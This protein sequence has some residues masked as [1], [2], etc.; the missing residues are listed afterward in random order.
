MFL[1]LLSQTVYAE[2]KRLFVRDDCRVRCLEWLK[3]IRFSV[4][5]RTLCIVVYQR[6]FSM[7]VRERCFLFSYSKRVNNVHGMVF[8]AWKNSWCS[9]KKK[10]PVVLPPATL[11]KSV[12]VAWRLR[13][14]SGRK[15]LPS[16]TWPSKALYSNRTGSYIM[17]TDFW[18]DPSP[19]FSLAS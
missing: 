11:G 2:S 5:C 12:R 13:S 14:A 15:V 8:T 19:I 4:C 17:V 16:P 9:A 7:G 6:V 10:P 1:K 18:S 3:A